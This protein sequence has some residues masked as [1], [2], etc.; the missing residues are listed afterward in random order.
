VEKKVDAMGRCKFVLFTA[1]SLSGVLFVGCSSASLPSSPAGATTGNS[2]TTSGGV[3]F[4]ANIDRYAY[5][6]A[7]AENAPS[8]SGTSTTGSIVTY[9]VSSS[10][11]AVA[12]S[13][14]AGPV[15]GTVFTKVRGDGN[16]NV[17]FISYDQTSATAIT[18]SEYSALT[19]V[20]TPPNAVI[21]LIRTFTTTLAS[22]L[23]A[24][25]ADGTGNV[26]ISEFNGTLLE[27]SPSAR[28]AAAPSKS[29]LFASPFSSIATDQDGALYA[30]IAG[31]ATITRYT[32]GFTS[33]APNATVD[34][35]AYV[36]AVTDLA[37]DYYHSIF[38]AGTDTHG[39]PSVFQFS[40]ATGS[41]TPANTISGSATL[42]PA[43]PQSIAVDP[44]D[45]IYVEGVRVASPGHDVF[46]VF[47][48]SATGNVAPTYT[49][50]ASAEDSGTGKGLALF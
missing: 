36:G 19:D 10:G 48:D 20:L 21:T 17:Y 27:F 16:G 26:F 1:F 22:N 24:M 39:N 42:L 45:N 41:P 28:G 46:L 2:G 25:A 18:V 29:I 9:P 31:S 4:S 43:G 23:T 47:S 11:S 15:S 14:F 32:A 50:T 30:A 38:I 40:G 13:P 34:V 49:F 7:A 5:N 44:Y 35:A 6:I 33:S 12:A 8:G 37:V 3:D